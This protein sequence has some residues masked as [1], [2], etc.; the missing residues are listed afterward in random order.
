MSDAPH[1]AIGSWSGYIYQGICAAYHILKLYYDK[2]KAVKDICKTGIRLCSAL[3][4]CK[5]I[6]YNL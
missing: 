2:G 6:K 1:T 4:E 3:V 5:I